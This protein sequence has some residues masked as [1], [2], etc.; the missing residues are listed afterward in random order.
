MAATTYDWLRDIREP[1]VSLVYV[2]VLKLQNEVPSR[3]LN[4]PSVCHQGIFLHNPSN[5][6]F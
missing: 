6:L 1:L 3:K 4:G 5:S 2:G